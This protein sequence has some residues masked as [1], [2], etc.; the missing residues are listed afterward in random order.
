MEVIV[1]IDVH[2]ILPL[3]FSVPFGTPKLDC[4]LALAL[5]SLILTLIIALDSFESNLLAQRIL[6]WTTELS[7]TY[8]FKIFGS[9]FRWHP[10]PIPH[11]AALDPSLR[12]KR[13]RRLWHKSITCGCS[14]L[15]T[16]LRVSKYILMEV[17]MML[18]NQDR[19]ETHTK[20]YWQIISTFYYAWGYQVSEPQ[21][22]HQ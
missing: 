22:T 2:I 3:H 21:F 16:A 9:H 5:V 20:I 17:N 7:L 13:I 6:M 1:N 4:L 8:A 19:V 15:L 18:L 14:K 10:I 12:I 11:P